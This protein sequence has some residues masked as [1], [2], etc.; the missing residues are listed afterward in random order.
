MT[1]ITFYDLYDNYIGS[2]P[3]IDMKIIDFEVE[4][5]EIDMNIKRYYPIDNLKG[6]SKLN[7]E[8]RR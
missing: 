7:V 1:Y 3:M 6:W 8:Y 5:E 2:L 4:T